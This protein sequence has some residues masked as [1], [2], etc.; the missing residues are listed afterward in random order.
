MVKSS[1]VLKDA[2]QGF[3]ADAKVQPFFLG[4]QVY[5]QQTNGNFPVSVGGCFVNMT[6]ELC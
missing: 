2:E 1:P 5:E 4:G 6:F 3:G